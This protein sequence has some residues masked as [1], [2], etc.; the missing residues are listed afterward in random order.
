MMSHRPAAHHHGGLRV[1]LLQGM[2]QLL[3]SCYVNQVALVEDEYDGG[4][5]PVRSDEVILEAG[6]EA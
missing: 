2:T 3:Q 1:E 5:N 4:G 6:V